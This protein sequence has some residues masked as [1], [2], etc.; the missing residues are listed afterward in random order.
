MKI[1]RKIKSI[2]KGNNPTT[3]LLFNLYLFAV[4]VAGFFS[5]TF[6]AGWLSVSLFMYFLMICL[7]ISVTYH[8]ALTHKAFLM[9]KWLERT[10]ATFACM[11]GTGSP[12]MWVMTHRQHHRFADKPGDPHPP[13]AVYKTIFGIYPRVNGYI[14]DIVADKYYKVWH[15]NYFGILSLWALFLYLVFGF[16]ALYF[17]LVVPVVC[18]VIVSNALNWF[19]HKSSFISYRNYELKD[20]SQNNWAM[21]IFAFGEGWHN[22]HHRHPGSASFGID[23]KEVD[24]SFLVIQLLEKL[25]LAKSVKRPNLN[26]KRI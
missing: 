11:A 10:F 3:L 23:K 4:L 5:A 7:G 12:I 6:S 9:P 14:R 15:R 8:R 25:N 17:I 19:G 24:I 13:E 16:N 22:N 21:A 20:H 26:L 1:P 2:I 18:S